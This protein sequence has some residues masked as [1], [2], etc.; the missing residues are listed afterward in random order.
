MYEKVLLTY[1]LA[2]GF[3]FQMVEICNWSPDFPRCRYCGENRFW[4]VV[5]PTG[6]ALSRY[7]ARVF[8]DKG[9]KEC[10]ALV[11]GC[12][13][14]LESLVL[15]KLGAR[16]WALDHNP[17]ALRLVRL[18]CKLNGIP[19][20]RTLLCC[21]RDS[22]GVQRLGPYDLLVGSDVLYGPEE[23]RW[24]IA[25]LQRAL[26]PRG[27]ALLADPV[28]DRAVRDFP[29]LLLQQGFRVGLSWLRARTGRVRLCHVRKEK[30]A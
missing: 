26:K 6:V 25:L 7:L 27:Q 9:L 11:V 30:A 13:V 3:R 29:R 20:V 28:R 19:P 21:W 12:G 17:Q 22:K 16:V 24:I 15:A 10:R 23:A 18:N 8:S 5:W 1:P 14:G 4:N 2:R